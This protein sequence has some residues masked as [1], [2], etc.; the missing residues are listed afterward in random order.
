MPKTDKYSGDS[1]KHSGGAS[2]GSTGVPSAEGGIDSGVQVA[3]KLGPEQ[4]ISKSTQEE[5]YTVIERENLQID[6]HASVVASGRTGRNT[7]Y[8]DE[9]A[10]QA[11]PCTHDWSKGHGAGAPTHSPD[12]YE[13]TQTGSF[14]QIEMP[15][16]S[17]KNISRQE[18]LPTKGQR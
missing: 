7:P 6:P 3:F 11:S 1:G 13:V 2:G 8:A 9:H 5:N 17:F 12:S 16:P 10:P 14:D 4:L 15:V 18:N